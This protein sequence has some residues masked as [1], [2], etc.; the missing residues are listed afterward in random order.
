MSEANRGG[1]HSSLV[2][3]NQVSGRE[4]RFKHFAI[5]LVLLVLVSFPEILLGWQSFFTR[6]F[7]NFGYPLAYYVRQSYRAGEIPLWDPYNFAGLPFLA[8]WNTLCLYPPS[9]LYVLLPLPWSLNCFNLA[10]LYLGG[11]GMFC[12]ARRWLR[13]GLAASVAGVG[14]AFGGVA[15]SAL[16]WPNNIAALGWLP[17][18]LLAGEKAAERGGRWCVVAAMVMALEF[19]AGAPEIV[20]MTWMG[21]VALALVKSWE[22]RSKPET[23]SST[24]K[25]ILLRL[26]AV[27]LIALGL[28]AI[29]F[30]PFLQLLKQSQRNYQFETGQWTLTWWGLGNFLVPL[31]RTVKGRDGI[32]FQM[33]QQWITSYYCGVTILVLALIGLL[34]E[35]SRHVRG[36]ALLCLGSVILAIGSQGG[37]YSWLRSAVPAIGVMRF[38]IKFIVPVAVLLPLLAG[39][40]LRA[41]LEGKVKSSTLGWLLAAV[42]GS[43]I[44]LMMWSRWR[45]YPGEDVG[46]T[47]SSGSMALVFL[48]ATVAAVSW[49]RRVRSPATRFLVSVLI[50]LLIYCDLFSANRRVNPV[51]PASV[52][53]QDC[54]E[55]NPRPA[56]GD[57]RAMVSSAA[58]QLL[59]ET[60]F[61]NPVADVRIPRQALLLNANLLER[62]PKLDGFFSLYLPR[63]AAVITKAS[64]EPGAGYDGLLDF[65]GV[66]HVSDP[67]Q[68]WKWNQRQQWLP[69][70]TLAG[71]AVFLDGT[72]EFYRLFSTQFNP[73]E[74]VVLPK[75]L[76]NQA[77]LDGPGRG[78]ILS[79]RIFNHRVDV[80]VEIDQPM[81]LVLAQADYPGWQARVDAERVPLWRANYGFQALAVPPGSHRVEVYFR[82][83][84]FEIGAVITG[85]T[86]IA[87]AGYLWHRRR[88]HWTV[89]E[90]SP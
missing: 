81:L 3:A 56:L 2:E 22:E 49:L 80:T 73:R 43:S 20:G 16:M 9:L 72:N 47:W 11:L 38:P 5:G 48:L 69:L 26:A 59:D 45:A 54:A 71:N 29:Q 61:P 17:F 90:T 44:S 58:H 7:S 24:T 65:L 31:F 78:K 88:T 28:V 70:A 40:G 15:V 51:V 32:F 25:Q 23:P 4:V 8:Q 84:P 74:Q 33:D 35:R 42:T 12:L 87:C 37:I 14:Y 53:V 39:Y 77:N 36:L 67:A 76:A 60:V 18:V 46:M 41:W 79:Q 89:A 85:V 82:S 27:F 57:G 66:S 21:V 55:I 6:D 62:V 1:E 30:L 68:P 83:A 50:G 63:T 10:H 86:L 19:L 34:S 13:D 75:E 52:M 64:R